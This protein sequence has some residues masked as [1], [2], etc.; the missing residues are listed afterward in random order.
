MPSLY[1][2][3][4][5][6]RDLDFRYFYSGDVEASDYNQYNI[7]EILESLGQSNVSVLYQQMALNALTIYHVAVRRLHADTTTISFSGVY[8]SEDGVIRVERGY[9]K[10]GRTLDKQ[11]VVG[12]ITTDS[13]IVLDQQVMDGGTADVS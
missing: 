9:N 4:E 11:V 6:L 2:I 8:E 12:Q 1:L 10:D 7:G 5:R 3:Q 13:G